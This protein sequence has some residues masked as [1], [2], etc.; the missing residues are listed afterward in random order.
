[1]VLFASSGI[2]ASLK[3]QQLIVF[4]STK[5]CKKYI[6]SHVFYC[7]YFPSCWH[8]AKIWFNCPLKILPKGYLVYI[9]GTNL[10]KYSSH[11]LNSIS[12]YGFTVESFKWILANVWKILELQCIFLFKNDLVSLERKI[13]EVHPT[14]VIVF[15]QFLTLFLKLSSLLRLLR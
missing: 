2:D 1:M 4:Y 12:H 5:L 14:S 9:S 11:L 15:K 7:K 6:L 8:L 13:V 3:Y 10:Q